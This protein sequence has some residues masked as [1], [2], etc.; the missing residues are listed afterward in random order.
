MR[1][2]LYDRLPADF[3]VVILRYPVVSR[4][5]VLPLLPE[6]L[7]LPCEVT[8]LFFFVVLLFLSVLTRPLLLDV[9]PDLSM[10]LPSFLTVMFEFTIEPLRVAVLA[11]LRSDLSTPKS[12]AFC[13]NIFLTKLFLTYQPQDDPSDGSPDARKIRR[14]CNCRQVWCY[15]TIRDWERRA[16]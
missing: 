7:R 15:K 2:E 11:V 1:V 6:D 3:V 14:R 10:T 4:L 16:V 5:T 13:R 8:V 12:V 9:L